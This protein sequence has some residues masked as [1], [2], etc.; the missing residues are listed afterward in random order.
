M[1]YICILYYIYFIKKGPLLSGRIQRARHTHSHIVERP[2]SKY[3]HTFTSQKAC[4]VKDYKDHPKV[5]H[6]RREAHDVRCSAVYM[7]HRDPQRINPARDTIGVHTNLDPS[8]RCVPLFCCPL[9]PILACG[10]V[11]ALLCFL[12]F[13]AASIQRVALR[14]V[15]NVCRSVQDSID[16][17]RLAQASKISRKVLKDLTIDLKSFQKIHGCHWGRHLDVRLPVPHPLTPSITP[18]T[19]SY[20]FSKTGT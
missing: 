13:F 6:K 19:L 7:S 2:I 5:V 8:L 14:A 18:F 15:A 17:K 16:L 10:G 1:Y 3:T 20:Q 9:Q 11:N 12:D 4:S